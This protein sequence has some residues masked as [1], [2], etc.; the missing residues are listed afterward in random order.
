MWNNAI[1]YKTRLSTWKTL[2][3]SV[4]TDSSAIL[5]IG[6]IPYVVF[7]REIDYY[8]PA[9]WPTPWEILELKV[10][11][12]SC[13]AVLIYHTLKISMP[14]SNPKLYLINNTEESWLV[15]EYNG[16]VYNFLPNSACT[17]SDVTDDAKIELVINTQEIKRC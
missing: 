6:K 2:R 13:V 10:L 17:L 8:T 1:N 5:E 12:R 7:H 16:L 14:E 3:A 15:V 11:C 9:S 4:V